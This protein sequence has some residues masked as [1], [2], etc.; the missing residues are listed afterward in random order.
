MNCH[1]KRRLTLFA[2]IALI[3]GQSNAAGIVPGYGAAGKLMPVTPI[4]DKPETQ[5]QITE[6]VGSA[7]EGAGTAGT[8]STLGLSTPVL[9]G[10]AVVVAAAAAIAIGASSS[11]G[12]GSS[13]PTHS[14]R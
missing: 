5:K 6:T 1:F 4:L 3:T 7:A 13:S 10:S 14:T 9:V 11:S 8:A 2:T 12:G